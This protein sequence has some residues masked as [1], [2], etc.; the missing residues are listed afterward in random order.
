MGFYFDGLSCAV[1]VI[2]CRC[3]GFGYDIPSRF[4]A[5]NNNCAV[6]AGN[7]IAYNRAILMLNRE[8]RSG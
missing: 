5:W 4:K 6:V 2:P 1:E 3:F 8:L 7:V